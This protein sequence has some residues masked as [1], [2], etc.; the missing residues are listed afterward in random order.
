MCMSLC[1]HACLHGAVSPPVAQSPS[2]ASP[3]PRPRVQHRNARSLQRQPERQEPDL[4]H[5]M[6]AS[7][8]LSLFKY[9][10][11]SYLSLFLSISLSLARSAL[12]P[13][14]EERGIE[15]ENMGGGRGPRAGMTSEG[16]YIPSS[17]SP[18]SRGRIRPMERL[19][20]GGIEVQKDGMKE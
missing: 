10:S 15:G 8:S 14:R 12:T 18:P 17:S 11:L 7:L 6:T 2:S 19:G 9:I 1:S 16:E 20:E 4:N 3:S 13:S 5:C